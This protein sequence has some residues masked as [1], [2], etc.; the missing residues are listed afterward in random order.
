VLP[1]R[2]EVRRRVSLGRRRELAGVRCHQ[3]HPASSLPPSPRRG[4]SGSSSAA[5]G[6]V[7]WRS[8]G[9][10]RPRRCRR[11][12]HGW[13]DRQVQDSA[14]RSAELDDAKGVEQG[15]PSWAVGGPRPPSVDLRLS[16]MGKN[17]W[18]P[19]WVRRVWRMSHIPSPGSEREA[20]GC[21]R[22]QM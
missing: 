8:G 11:R 20:G 17:P 22:I 13:R 10:H 16:D 6:G 14:A 9:R 4:G 19:S 5:R 15:S 1:L 3:P 18:P 2:L 7:G 21:R 12:A